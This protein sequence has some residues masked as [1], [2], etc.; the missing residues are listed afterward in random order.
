V[1]LVSANRAIA[2]GLPWF[3]VLILGLMLQPWFR[4][5][6][7]QAY[8]FQRWVEVLLLIVAGCCL[9]FFWLW[10][11][12]LAAPIQWGLFLLV[13]AMATSSYTSAMGWLSWI[14]FLRFWLWIILLGCLPLV[15][16]SA[17]E[18]THRKLGW[19]VMIGL[20]V[21][22][23]YAGVG[24]FVL[25]S[26]GVYD[27]TFAVAGFANVNHAAGFLALAVMILPDFSF[28]DL[29]ER[30]F[31]KLSAALLV[32]ALLVMLLF[33]IG[34]RGSFLGTLNRDTQ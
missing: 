32:A 13:L 18:N 1:V 21:Y 25:A 19:A 6:A 3:V 2:Q 9:P 27:R 28:D 34:S 12:L 29:P 10:V 33:V 30:N 24:V 7:I 22:A 16:C 31:W 8:D 17:A 14:S 20:G 11:R 15:L 4:P 26:N 5:A 23:C